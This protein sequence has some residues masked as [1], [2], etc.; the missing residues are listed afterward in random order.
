[1]HYIWERQSVAALVAAAGGVF[2]PNKWQSTFEG[3]IVL[4]FT[5]AW[6]GTLIGV[7]TDG[8]AASSVVLVIMTVTMSLIVGTYVGFRASDILRVADGGTLEL[9]IPTEGDDS[10]ND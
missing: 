5:T 6:I 4:L 7:L 3:L 10:D 2:M 8:F 9:S 1:M